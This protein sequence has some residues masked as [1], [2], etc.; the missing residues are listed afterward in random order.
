MV[1]LQPT[2]RSLSVASVLYFPMPRFVHFLNVT[3]GL[4][5]R[6]T[7]SDMLGSNLTWAARAGLGSIQRKW[8][9]VESLMERSIRHANRLD[10]LRGTTPPPMDRDAHPLP[11]GR[12]RA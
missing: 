2:K 6:H 10:F 9:R 12:S 1:G 4:H 3:P 11:T 5:P 7:S 8:N